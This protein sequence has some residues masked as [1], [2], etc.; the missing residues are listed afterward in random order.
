MKA[1]TIG[2]YFGMFVAWLSVSIFVAQAAGVTTIET[3]LDNAVQYIKKIVLT[4]DNWSDWIILDWNSGIL[5]IKWD[6]WTLNA[7]NIHTKSIEPLS[8]T[9]DIRW[10]NLS[11]RWWYGYGY[12]YG[13]APLFLQN[14]G[15]RTIIGGPMNF[16]VNGFQG[17]TISWFSIENVGLLS[18][19]RIMP[20]VVSPEEV[21]NNIWYK[22]YIYWWYGYGYGYGRAP[23]LLQ[24]GGGKVGIGTSNPSTALDVF[25]DT[26]VAWSLLVW[27][28]IS[29]D[30]Q[31]SA[32]WYKANGK[33]G[34]DKC[35]LYIWQDWTAQY[36]QY[37]KWILIAAWAGTSCPT[38]YGY[39][40]WKLDNY[41]YWASYTSQIIGAYNYAYSNWLTIIPIEQAN[42]YWS[43]TITE[44][45]TIMNSYVSN[46][47]G[48]T[49]IVFTGDLRT[50][51]TQRDEA[52]RIATIL[53]WVTFVTN[54][55]QQTVMNYLKDIWV[56]STIGLQDP[57]VRG[58]VFMRLQRLEENRKVNVCHTVENTLSCT[59]WLSTCPS[60]C[61]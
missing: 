12:G 8:A 29:V 28:E 49:W 25:W 6:Y 20:Y 33:I 53:K 21:Q 32:G 11:I 2:N 44:L 54:N 14:G 4:T 26:H 37:E 27:N 56:Y 17:V 61:Q 47:I 52:L 51:A 50:T 43:I 23:L 34:I 10:S 31:I 38:N 7:N 42:L 36:M 22:L 46:N 59:L 1:K 9:W 30:N 55:S 3:N 60:Q 5:S 35:M 41:W 39:G 58:Y 13:R 16:P 24:N 48:L 15:G 40:Y 57:L 45:N 19:E 18:A